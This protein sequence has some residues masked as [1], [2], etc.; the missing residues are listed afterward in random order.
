[1]RLRWTS[2][3]AKDLESISDD[4]LDQHPQLAQSTVRR[5]YAEIKEL[6]RFP[7]LGPIGRELGTRELIFAGLPYIVVFRANDA[8]VDILRIYH[9]GQDWP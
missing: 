7:A 4:L 3:A 8:R 9:G 1:M 2:A 5:V 6:S